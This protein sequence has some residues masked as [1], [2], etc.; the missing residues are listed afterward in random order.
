MD[1]IGADGGVVGPLKL[2]RDTGRYE[3]R[4]PTATYVQ[5]KRVTGGKS[6]TDYEAWQRRSREPGINR[7]VSF[8]PAASE[9]EKPCMQVA[10]A[11][12]FAYVRDGALVVSVDLDT[13]EPGT[14]AMYGDSC[15]P[16]QVTVQGTTVF[17]ALS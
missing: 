7:R 9:D 11:L 10:G 13:A 16:V 8:L 17:E 6:I 3:P 5:W 12:V 15:V 1:I 2:N 14:F 4:D